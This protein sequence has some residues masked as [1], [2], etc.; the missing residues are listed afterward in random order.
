[1]LRTG[2]LPPPLQ[3][4]SLRALEETNC[5]RFDQTLVYLCALFASL[6]AYQTLQKLAAPPRW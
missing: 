3:R 5:A 2:T 1:M 4:H 6:P